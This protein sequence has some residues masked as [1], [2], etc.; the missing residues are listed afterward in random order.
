M[1]AQKT[2]LNQSKIKNAELYLFRFFFLYFLL[3]L[4]PIDGQFWQHIFSTNWF[5][6]EYRDIFYLT[7]YQP[8]FVPG[9]PSFLNWGIIA[10]LAAVGTVIWAQRDGELQNRD[11]LYYWL[12]VAL[13]Y[14]LA[15]GV[16]AYGFLKFFPLQAPPPSLSNLNTAYGD[17]SDWK[18]FSLSL[19]VV[20]G[21]QSFLGLVEIVGGALLLYRKTATIGTLIIL[22]FTGNVFFSN[23][24]YNGGEYVYSAYLIA[25]ALYLFAFD[26]IRLFTLLSLERPTAP[27]VFQPVLLGWQKNGRL[28]LKTAFILFFVV[29][30]G[31]QTR[32]GYAEGQYHFPRTAGLKG[33]E[34]IYNVA[35]FK[36]NGRAIPYSKTNPQRWQDV[37]FEKWNTVSIK[38]SRNVKVVSAPTEEIYPLDAER[39]YEYAGALGR[40]YY[41]YEVQGKQEKLILNN[42]N[43]NHAAEKLELNISRPNSSTIV[44]EGLNENRDSVYAV[45]HKLDKRY[46][47]FEAQKTGRR[48]GLTL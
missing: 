5:K 6:P 8:Q 1:P 43:P 29:L 46:L 28:V 11:S 30:Y 10:V 27:N 22:P 20:A 38:S 26:G 34:G 25:I 14:R 23:L 41:S 42:R 17:F 36:L 7:R 31:L 19:G 47:I 2:L 15:I 33:T 16:I 32:A 4:L 45:L 12:R 3:Q 9:G 21:Y 48:Q 35:E 24:A 37:V 13:R 44:L 18:I 39:N 40:H